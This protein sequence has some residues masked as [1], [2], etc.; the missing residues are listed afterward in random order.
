MYVGSYLELHTTLIGWM[1]YDLI[2][3]ILLQT[4]AIFVPILWIVIRNW[5]EAS[6]KSVK[7]P[8]AEMSA[9]KNLWDLV[10]ALLVIFFA[11]VPAWPI[12]PTTLQY[13]PSPQFTE[14]AP[15]VVTQPSDPTTFSD[16]IGQV[17]YAAG[18]PLVPIWWYFMM[19]FS[20]GVSHAVVSNLPTPGD[21]TAAS[22]QIAAANIKDPKLAHD[23]QAF[24]TDCFTNARAKYSQLYP[25]GRLPGADAPT[26][27]YGP[28]EAD[29][30]GSRIF[31]ETPGLYLPCGSANACGGNILTRSVEGF[32]INPSCADWWG[33]LK[34]RL[35]DQTDTGLWSGL[36]ATITGLNPLSADDYET[37]Q[38]K[39]MLNNHIS[40]TAGSKFGSDHRYAYVS[41]I[42]PINNVSNSLKSFAGFL[43]ATFTAGTFAAKMHVVKMAL[44]MIKAILLMLIYISLP[45]VL[46]ASAYEVETVFTMSVVMFSIMMLTALWAIAA[47]TEYHLTVAIYPDNQIVS[48]LRGSVDDA[49]KSTITRYFNRRPIF[50][51]AHSVVLCTD[52]GRAEKCGNGC[53]SDYR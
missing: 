38:L 20:A 23:L 50:T 13:Q 22:Q 3:E 29:W 2:W 32:D 41:E 48:F 43:G 6:L 28:E 16:T 15:A 27:T 1:I 7:L 42:D 34:T 37:V 25:S 5:R 39:T 8:P 10:F 45:I 52:L 31:M 33:S 17:T 44:P 47:W 14:T 18:N 40:K 51:D 26:L 49:T 11:C 12:A 30:V 35:I 19:R 53:K 9:K 36:K 46:M 4:G 21:L 24:I